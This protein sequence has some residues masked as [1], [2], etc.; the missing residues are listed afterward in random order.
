MDLTALVKVVPVTVEVVSLA[1][2]SG[3]LDP[4]DAIQ[5]QTA[6]L[7]AG[8]VAIVTRDPSGFEGS[9]LLVLTPEEALRALQL[10]HVN[11]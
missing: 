5:L 9:S 4:E 7:H 1:L 10:N 2:D 8:I 3:Q 6:R 11:Q